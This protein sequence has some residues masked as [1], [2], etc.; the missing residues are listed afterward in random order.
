MTVAPG[1]KP[2]L[3]QDHRV[4]RTASVMVACPG[5]CVHENRMVWA[6]FR[7]RPLPSLFFWP[8]SGV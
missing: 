4:I 5:L 8:G 3:S 6:M 1:A 2:G 7:Q